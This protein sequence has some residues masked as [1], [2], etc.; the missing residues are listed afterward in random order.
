[1][2][3]FIINLDEDRS[4][5][6]KVLLRAKELGVSVERYPAVYGKSISET[7]KRRRVSFFKWRCIVGQPPTDGEIG[8]ALSHLGVY[9]KI[10]SD[11]ID[12]AC[13]LEDDVILDERFKVQ[14]GKIEEFCLSHPASMI[15]L[16]DKLKTGREDWSIEPSI[17]ENGLGSYG[18]VVT[19]LAA[20]IALKSNTPL[21]CPSDFFKWLFCRSK[22]TIY[23]AFPAV[24]DYDKIYESKTANG[25][26]AV[27]RMSVVAKMRYRFG[28]LW[29]L[30]IA[31]IFV[32]LKF[33]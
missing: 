32:S 20:K 13:I 22:V 26:K 1:M 7:E 12:V 21:K 30:I 11:Q 15:M 23:K 25:R 28:R 17:K 3:I 14:L 18:Y 27:S 6:E 4:R 19:N 29:G 5:F 8:C 10:L 24:C 16:S 9:A 31:R 33:W 2:K